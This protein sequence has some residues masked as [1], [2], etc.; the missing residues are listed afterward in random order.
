MKPLTLVVF[1]CLV[2]A[3]AAAGPAPKKGPLF[4][5]EVTCFLGKIDSRSKCTARSDLPEPKPKSRWSSAM[6]CG[7]AGQ[8]SETC[9]DYLGSE[10]GADIYEVTRR[11]PADAQTSETVTKKIRF[12]G[13]R[14]I[15]FEDSHQVVVI[16]PT[17]I[18]LKGK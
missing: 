10:D 14:L 18:P 3:C 4:L 15:I 2:P 1:A 11:F 8:A 16:D 17:T 12:A 5:A 13:K 6:T 7:S 9:W